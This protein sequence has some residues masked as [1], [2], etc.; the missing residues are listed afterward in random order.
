MRSFLISHTGEG[1]AI[2]V[3]KVKIS[4]REAERD[5]IAQRTVWTLE[6]VPLRRCNWDLNV[7]P[8]KFMAASM[9]ASRNMYALIV[10]LSN[11]TDSNKLGGKFSRH[12]V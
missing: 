9:K 8:N 1:L 3:D 6:S 5:L 10:P 2:K 7:Y 12:V 11:I 4:V